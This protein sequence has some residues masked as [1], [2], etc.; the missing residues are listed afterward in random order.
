MS[1]R[2]TKS[3]YGLIS[4]LF[5]WLIATLFILQFYWIYMKNYWFPKGSKDGIRYLVY[6]HKSVGAILLGLAVL[7]IV[8]RMVNKKPSL[9]S[10]MP[11][12]ETF[13]AKLTHF[14]LAAVIVVMPLSGVLM[15]MGSGKQIKIFDAWVLPMVIEKN[16]M[17][18]SNA[19]AIHEWC[20]Y[21]VI[22][23]VVLHVLAALKHHFVDRDDILKR[24]L[25]S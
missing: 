18:A 5:H 24:M 21:V 16:K 13:L 25:I 2:N 10:S 20:S 19:H 14:V 6:Y 23:A 1:I 8:W 7:S 11:T 12:Y 3:N 4:K 15:S 22:G 17:I 9:P